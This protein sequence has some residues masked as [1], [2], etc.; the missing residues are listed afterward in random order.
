MPK[1]PLE[2]GVSPPC[3]DLN[4]TKCTIAIWERRFYFSILFRLKGGVSK[5]DTFPLIGAN[6]CH[7]ETIIKIVQ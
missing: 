7:A 3:K 1:F 6:L 2:G 5:I 4:Q